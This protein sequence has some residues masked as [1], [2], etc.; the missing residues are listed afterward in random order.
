MIT[1]LSHLAYF[2]KCKKLSFYMIEV[3]YG[4]VIEKFLVIARKRGF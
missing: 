4:Y 2:R 1:E 3:I